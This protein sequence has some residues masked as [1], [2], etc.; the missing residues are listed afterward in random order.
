MNK[1]V[2]EPSPSERKEKQLH[3]RGEA[4]VELQNGQREFA[5]HLAK[6]FSIWPMHIF[7]SGP[8]TTQFIVTFKEKISVEEFVWR[9]ERAF[10]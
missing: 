6:R 1:R 3:E 7:H 2:F 10:E 4:I 5:D 8:E 9:M